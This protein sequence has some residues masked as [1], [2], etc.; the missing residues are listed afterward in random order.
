MPAASRVA[1]YTLDTGPGSQTLLVPIDVDLSRGDEIL[2]EL[3]LT[4]A[5]T[6]AGD[7]LDVRLQDCTS[8]TTA[9]VWNTR[10]RF[11]Q[12]IGTVTVSAAAPEVRRLA[13]QAYGTLPDTEEAYEPSGSAGA[14]EIAAGTVLNGPFP[15]VRRLSAGG[16]KQSWR[17]KID[18]VDADSDGDFEGR[19]TV[20]LRT[21]SGPTLIGG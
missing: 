6:D 17:L 7:T 5:Q 14:A 16:R 13:L 8:L 12:F 19:I 20:W 4:K 18:V 10:A 21:A 11:A 15:G 9:E 1:K 2:I 3:E